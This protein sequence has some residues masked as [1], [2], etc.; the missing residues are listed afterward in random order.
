[1]GFMAL[2]RRFP[3]RCTALWLSLP[4]GPDPSLN[5]VGW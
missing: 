3:C 4:C 2:S 1:M 5:S